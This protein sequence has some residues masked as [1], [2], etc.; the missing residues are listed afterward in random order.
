[1]INE[2]LGLLMI[3]TLVYYPL[4]ILLLVLAVRG[5]MTVL[6]VT[7]GS[8]IA[9]LASVTWR[10][11][12]FNGSFGLLIINVCAVAVLITGLKLMDPAFIDEFWQIRGSRGGFAGFYY[13]E[14]FSRF[15]MILSLGGTFGVCIV[16]ALFG[17]NFAASAALA[18]DNPPGH[19]QLWGIAGQF[20]KLF[21]VAIL[22]VFVPQLAIILWAGGIDTTYVEYMLLDDYIVIGSAIYSMWTICLMAAAS[23]L[24]YKLH[25]VEDEVR[26]KRDIEELAGVGRSTGPQVD[27]KALRQARMGGVAVAPEDL[28]EDEEE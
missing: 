2:I 25:L 28:I 1:M 13:I 19:H 3:F 14:L 27:L 11:M 17:T 22:F 24:A 15:P 5:G 8:D 18:V 7:T 4:Q 23:A 12:R 21:F 9:K 16:V 26:R 6:K 20:G 10:V